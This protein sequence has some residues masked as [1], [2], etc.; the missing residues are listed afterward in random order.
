MCVKLV[1]LHTNRYEMEGSV[2]G[3]SS[4]ARDIVTL[5]SKYEVLLL[6]QGL[7]RP[8]PERTALVFR[9]FDE[10]IPHL[11]VFTKV[12]KMIREEMHDSI[13]SNSYTSSKKDS[14]PAV[15]RVPFFA[16]VNQVY[17]E[18]N[19]A[20]DELQEQLDVVKKRLFEKHKQYEEAQDNI[21]DLKQQILGLE[22]TI[23]NL[24]QD[25]NG[26]DAEIER[27]NQAMEDAKQKSHMTEHSLNCD[28]DELKDEIDEAKHNINYLNG[29]KKGYD[30]M[31]E[32]FLYH[33]GSDDAAS[34]LKVPVIAT[35]RAHLIS[36][37]ESAKKIELQILTVMNSIIEEFDKFL[38]DHKT[39]LSNMTL[40]ENPNDRNYF[41]QELEVERADQ[42]LWVI[43]ERFK[44]SIDDM[45]TELELI[46]QHYTMLQEQLQNLEE[47]KPDVEVDKDAEEQRD[48]LAARLAA[49]E[50]QRQREGG[51]DRA[52]SSLSAGLEEEKPDAGTDPFIP[53]ERVFSK[54]AAMMYTSSNKG[55]NWHEFQDAKYC[56]SCGEKT[57]ICPHKV[58]GQDMV[59]KVPHGCTH[60]KVT[61]PKVRINQDLMNSIFGVENLV[62]SDSVSEEASGISSR[63][64]TMSPS[65]KRFRA[66]ASMMGK[67][68]AGN[69]A[70]LLASLSTT[71]T[72]PPGSTESHMV[73]TVKKL[74]DDFKDRATVE[75]TIPRP[76]TMGRTLSVI[77]QF[78][79]FV[80][81]Q[82]EAG[83]DEELFSVLDNLYYF[84]SDR[85]LKEDITYLTMHDLLSSVVENMG[86]EKIIQVFGH[87][88]MGNL[89][90]SCF[91]YL[92]LMADFINL[93]EWKEVEDF[94]YF[95]AIVYPFLG[96]D[97]L[98]TLQMGY[99]SF[100]ENK[101]SKKRVYEF[102]MY[103]I[104]KYREPRFQ[105]MEGKLLQFPSQESGMTESE[106]NEGVEHLVPIS[107]EKLKRILYWEAEAHVQMDGLTEVVPVMRLA[108]IA[109]Y[110]AL[111]Q[112]APIIKQTV[113]EKV[114]K[115][116]MREA[117]DRG[118]TKPQNEEEQRQENKIMTYSS[119]RNLA[120]SV[121]RQKASRK[122]REKED[123]EL[124]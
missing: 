33:P 46:R 6:E 9:V 39:E 11:G 91:R 84:M 82:D 99:T 116:R 26:R 47:N 108:Q 100:S 67:M 4:S 122:R 56:P 105:D 34:S 104:L 19:E 118:G 7:P 112:I 50:K 117:G 64:N 73:Y 76:L 114:I 59:I 95:A 43:Q 49:I 57:L 10:L 58:C 121:A 88:L 87:V 15:Q 70:E 86:K 113:A 28:I 106:F 79:S 96:E 77:E 1:V 29:F 89:D 2:V 32:A 61:R 107:N 35:K 30:D 51:S 98:E 14:S 22:Q 21:E 90:G 123:Q 80:L 83:E 74:W 124:N 78:Y 120:V 27:L 38:E 111:Q 71:R 31:Q 62:E 103:V 12:M 68:G 17:K 53:H 63:S 93:V 109:S 54:Y 97:D 41:R 36:N 23:D 8:S 16:L 60:M 25:V 48:M 102:M 110:L 81:W 24:A 52:E 101:I 40:S 3:K 18:R 37:I 69:R 13:F 119:V 85:Y 72:P 94:R 65:T 44:K 5:T 55:K 42:E 66:M 75:R 115:A 20:A 92:L 45:N